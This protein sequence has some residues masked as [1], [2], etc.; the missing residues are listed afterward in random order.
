[1]NV[2]SEGVVVVGCCCHHNVS[3]V[4]VRPCQQ[5]VT[6]P[7]V[8]EVMAVVPVVTAADCVGV[9]GGHCPTCPNYPTAPAA[10]VDSV[11]PGVSLTN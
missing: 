7:L 3:D 1:M 8:G 9:A 10:G 2:S 4:P 5:V 6:A 11:G